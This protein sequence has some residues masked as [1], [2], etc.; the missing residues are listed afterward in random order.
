MYTTHKLLS[1]LF[2]AA[3]LSLACERDD[4]DNGSGSGL[5]PTLT[6]IQSNIFSVNCAL[7]GC[8]AGASP[9]QGMNLS[10]GQAFSNIVNVRSNEV[11]SLFRVE[12]GNPEDSYL[13]MKITGATGIV[14]SR[15][16]LG[17]SPLSSEEIETI[18]QWIEDGAQNN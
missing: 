14:G 11:P 15:M 3:I 8:H 4:E 1:F 7:S 18:R 12:P 2:I 9:Q 13:F 16:P 5:Q 10:E 6:S 17:R